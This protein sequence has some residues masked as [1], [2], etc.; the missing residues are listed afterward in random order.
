[1]VLISRV[2]GQLLVYMTLSKLIS[3]LSLFYCSME[4]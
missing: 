1:M 4:Y 3:F 2:S